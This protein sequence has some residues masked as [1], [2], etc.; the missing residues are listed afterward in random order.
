MLRFAW[1]VALATFGAALCPAQARIQDVIYEK[2]GGAAFTMDVFLPEKPNKAAVVWMVSGGWFSNHEGINQDLAKLFTS[3]GFT[4]FEVVHGAQPRYKIP[5]IV[6]QVRK[7]VRFI[8]SR[9]N[10]YGIEPNRIGVAGASAGGHLS[11]MIGASGDANAVAAIF[12]PTDFQN[13]GAAGRM[14]FDNPMMAPFIPAF[15]VDVKG[16]KEKIE[17]TARATSP[18][19]YVTAKYPPTLMVHGDKDVLVPMQQSQDMGRALDKAGVKNKVVIIPG[20]G[21][22]DKTTMPALPEILAWF[23]THLVAGGRPG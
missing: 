5:E 17:E 10:E 4:V 3:N 6:E 20:G 16:P 8:R 18:I 1:L 7:A 14:P 11:L 13:Y 2:S 12:P 19:A 21:H 22:D 23:R 9:S 15:G